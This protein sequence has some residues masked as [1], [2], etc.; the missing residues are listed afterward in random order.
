LPPS[1]L[2]KTKLF[3]PGLREKLVNRQKISDQLEKGLKAR[4][5]FIS[6]P[7]GFGKTTLLTQWLHNTGKKAGWL[8]LDRSDNNFNRFWIYFIN[9]LQNINPQ[10]GSEILPILNLSEKPQTEYFL[11]DL[12]N[13]IMNTDKEFIIILDDFHLIEDKSI[14]DGISFLLDNLPGN[15]HIYI[16]SRFEP[17]SLPVSRLRAR[18]ELVEIK[19][20]RLRFSRDD[21]INFFNLTGL[22][23][24]NDEAGQLEKKTE[25]WGLGLQLALVS[26][27][28]SADVSTFIREFTGNNRYIVDYLLDEILINQPPSLQAFLF[29]TSILAKFNARL[30]SRV[31]G[32]P[33]SQKIIEELERK[34]LFI[35]PLDDTRE[36]YRY[37]NLL[38]DLLYNRLEKEEPGK[39]RQ[40]HIEAARWF[41]ENELENEAISHAFQAGELNLVGELISGIAF[42][43]VSKGEVKV[44]LDWLE[45]LPE[46]IIL[47]RPELYIYY[48][49]VLTLTSQL[50]KAEI[51]LA[52]VAESIK[53][54][55]INFPVYPQIANIRATIAR[56]K[57]DVPEIIK[58]SREALEK[59]KI[60]DN[61]IQATAHFNLGIAHMISGNYDES[62]SQ[63]SQSV[64]F[65]Q[66][67]G[68]FLTVI[69][70]NLCRSRI[71]M[72]QGNLPEAEKLYR[73]L[74]E[75]TKEYGLTRHSISGVIMVDLAQINYHWNN[76][77]ISRQLLEAGLNLTRHSY[78]ADSVYGFTTG[79]QIKAGEKDYEGLEKIIRETENFAKS[80]NIAGL[81]LKAEAYQSY[82]WIMKGK[83]ELAKSW[84]NE[85]Q[86]RFKEGFAFSAENEVLIMARFLIAQ[87]KFPEAGSLL[88]ALLEKVENVVIKAA[89]IRIM[90]LR[91][92]IF[93]KKNEVG[94]ASEYLKQAI[95]CG[96]S[97]NFL[98]I[99]LEEN[100]LIPL[101]RETN[102]ELKS[103]RKISLG[104]SNILSQLFDNYLKPGTGGSLE[105]ESPLS[106][107]ELEIIRLI[108]SGFSNQEIGEKLFVSLNTIKTHIK[109][110]YRKLE[111]QTRT[112]AIAKAKKMGL[113]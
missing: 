100:P 52:K 106:E 86:K 94:K 110:L 89:I 65:N 54:K 66:K 103:R 63:F 18:K 17:E 3:I 10:T 50:E 77:E 78:N 47:S 33:E 76:P 43:M 36:W 101:L 75:D 16:A 48:A 29:E 35:V 105:V 109:N 27:Q 58:Y 83:P 62:I 51:I 25:G 59:M 40:L 74:Q 2:L 1:A 64:P 96:E 28:E 13:V 12:I 39:I 7:A 34:N 11:A 102:T 9:A 61:F 84:A 32:N 69:A 72:L 19:A 112:Q 30:C 5:T 92:L 107:R 104:Y 55:I 49:W 60:P 93:H 91:S 56:R 15:L 82:L 57:G 38:S 46:A 4:L 68:N 73:Q 80:K 44:L 111:V 21:I 98:N 37:H 70:A 79:L 90:L 85:M 88:T 67:A 53:N 45:K 113:F 41:A 14:L 24:S 23:I 95:I 26:I 99:Y 108:E 81:L 22:E 31:T 6:A 71:I 20:A 87:E 42:N 97:G 8:S